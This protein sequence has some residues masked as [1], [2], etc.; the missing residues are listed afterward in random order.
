MQ[1]VGGGVEDEKGRGWNFLGDCCGV[2]CLIL[3]LGRKGMPPP[4]LKS[5]KRSSK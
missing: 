2:M 5:S 4:H 1:A 3:F